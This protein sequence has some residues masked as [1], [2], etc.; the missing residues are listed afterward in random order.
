[1]ENHVQ[2][3]YH[4]EAAINSER[5]KKL[6]VEKVYQETPIGRHIFSPN[7]ELANTKWVNFPPKFSVMQKKQLALSAYSWPS[8]VM[9]SEMANNFFQ[10]PS[11]RQLEN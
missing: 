3:K 7:E 9:A 11:R 4:K 5:M 8:G 2:T 6:P 10:Q 1:M